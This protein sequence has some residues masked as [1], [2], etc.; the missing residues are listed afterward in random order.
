MKKYIIR[1]I[2]L[3]IAGTITASLTVWLS[4]RDIP[5]EVI[6][7]LNGLLVMLG[8]WGL[9]KWQGIPMQ[10][11]QAWLADEGLYKG[12]QSGLA[13]DETKA[14]LVE[15][16]NSPAIRVERARL[17]PESAVKKPPRHSKYNPL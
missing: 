16:V 13:G 5:G 4:A 2:I 15:A 1:R 9:S 11:L 6:A 7:A 8:M 17:V 14:A 10:E 3:S 12:P